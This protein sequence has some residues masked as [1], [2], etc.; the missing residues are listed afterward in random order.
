MKLN[1]NLLRKTS[2]AS[3][4]V[5]SGVV[6]KNSLE[7][8]GQPNHSV[9]KPLGMVLFGLGWLLVARALSSGR[10]NK[11]KTVVPCLLILASV[12]MMKEKV[13]LPKVVPGMIRKVLL[14]LVF[15]GAWVVLGLNVSKHLPGNKKYYGL[16]ASAAVLVSMMYALP[17][18][19]KK[20]VVDGPGMPLFTLAWVIVSVLNSWR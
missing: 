17:L 5:L 6:V 14:P 15:A 16:A 4:M 13:K 3:L 11:M 18:Q 19:R 8:M 12:V 2:V 20:C 1:Q 10:R 7:Q 9:G